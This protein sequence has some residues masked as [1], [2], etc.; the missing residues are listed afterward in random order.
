MNEELRQR[1]REIAIQ[2]NYMGHDQADMVLDFHHLE[3]GRRHPAKVAVSLNILS[4]GRAKELRGEMERGAKQEEKARARM[5]KVRTTKS[6]VAAGAA[7]VAPVSAAAEPEP[8]A[9]SSSLSPGQRERSLQPNSLVSQLIAKAIQAGASDLHLHAHTIPFMRVHGQLVE[10]FAQKIDQKVLVRTF[11]ELLSEE[12]WLVLTEEGEV[13]ACLNFRDGYRLRTN[14]FRDHLGFSA[15]FRIILPKVP[16][17]A[18][19]GLPKTV[20]RL[21]DFHQGLI[22]IAGSAGSGKTTTLASLIRRLNATRPLHIIT[23]EDPIEFLFEPEKSSIT[24]RQVGVHTVS[25]A[26]A[27]HAA[28]REDPDVIVVSEMRDVRTMHIALTAAETGHLVMGTLHTRNVESTIARFLDAFGEEEEQMRGIFADALRGV[29]VQQL[30]PGQGVNSR[31]FPAVELMF[32]NHAISHCIRQRKLHQIQSMIQAGRQSHMITWED[33][34]RD[35]QRRRTI[36]N[37]AGEDLLVDLRRM[38]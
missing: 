17:L 33:S 26:H 37:K 29:M 31:R 30:L 14:F 3:N 6:P 9:M 4:E 36:N 27:L 20:A 12:Q 38:G 2:G 5:D 13:D 7:P 23:L 34:I 11:Q 19:L 16:T 25:Y 21:I 35:L 28:L 22:L 10:G 1:F 24:Q 8:V 15:A 32:N 18:E